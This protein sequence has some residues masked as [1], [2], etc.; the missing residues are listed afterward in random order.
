MFLKSFYYL[1]FL[2]HN[3]LFSTEQYYKACQI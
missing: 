3:N 1:F 2:R